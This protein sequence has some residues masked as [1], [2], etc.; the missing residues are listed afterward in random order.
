MFK[1]RATAMIM[2]GLCF[3]SIPSANL[4]LAACVWGC[5]DPVGC[6]RQNGGCYKAVPE[7]CA[8]L[9]ANGAD[10]NQVCNLASPYPGG[11]IPCNVGAC[12]DCDPVCMVHNKT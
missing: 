11:Q 2:I 5:K 6:I 4:L 9:W 1:K 3:V 8:I 10:P 7:T 12:Y